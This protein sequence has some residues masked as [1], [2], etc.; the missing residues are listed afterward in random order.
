VVEVDGWTFH[1]TR[2]RFEDDRQRDVKLQIAGYRVARFTRDRIMHHPH[3]VARDLTA[4]LI[5]GRPHLSE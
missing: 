4:L 3:E 1:K 5:R 2:R